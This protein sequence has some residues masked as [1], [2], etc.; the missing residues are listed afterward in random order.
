MANISPYESLSIDDTLKKLN[1]SKD[2][3]LASAEAKKRLEQYGP[4]AL[5]EKE[6]SLFKKLFAYFWGPIPWMIEIAG[7]LSGL[8][9]RWP[10]LIVI[11]SMLLINALLGFFQEYKAGNAIK[12]LKAKLALKA[13]VLR[14]SKW[15]DIAAKELVPG[16]IIQ[17]EIGN[18]IPADIKLIDGQYLSVDQ[19]SLTGESLPVD[20]KV[21]DMAYSG[22]TAKMGSMK[23]IVTDT[24]MDTFFGKTAKLVK[25]A[26]P[27]SHFQKTI[28]SI[29]NFLI[30]L[31]LI[32]C[33]II[34]VV[35][36]YRMKVT[37]NIHEDIGSIVIF[38]LVLVVAGIPVAQPAVLS[39]TM[40]I[41]ANR[42]ASMKAIVSKLT[43]I[44]ELANMEVLC[45]D[46][47]GTLTKNQLT[48]GQSALI[49]GKSEEDLMLYAA[50]ASN[51]DHPDAIDHCIIESLKNKEELKK[52]KVQKFLPFDPVSKKTE[53]TISMD[54]STFEVS[55]GAP[56]VILELCSS[57]D[58]LKD[59]V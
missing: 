24:G 8:L 42:L 16:D 1:S 54:N 17:I 58:T 10:D 49:E 25:E 13:R 28:L 23:G 3:G 15:L 56:Q 57:K 7:L 52:Y 43:A 31:T 46:K 50:L 55:K 11:A 51:I 59:K 34:L 4:N 33:A 26:S 39:A 41:G 30:S 27:V 29:G 48:V 14:G 44:E 32:I 36:L 45:S 22:T 38:I 19:S 37:H 35:S 9:K 21:G 20:K 47:T 6:E 40:A 5:D 2:E 18:I 53:S 12:A